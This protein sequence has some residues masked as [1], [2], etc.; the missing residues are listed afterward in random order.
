MFTEQLKK[1]YYTI[2]IKPDQLGKWVIADFK[3]PA[4]SVCII[5]SHHCVL[6]QRCATADSWAPSF[7]CDAEVWSHHGRHQ[8]GWSHG[9]SESLQGRVT[10][11][12]THTRKLHK[13]RESYWRVM[14]FWASVYTIIAHFCTISAQTGIQGISAVFYRVS[15]LLFTFVRCKYKRS[16]V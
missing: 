2:L 4:I 15:C 14:S 9:L 6:F 10:H 16:R 3:P 7:L 8:H 13:Y 1:T 11:R 5:Q 12:R